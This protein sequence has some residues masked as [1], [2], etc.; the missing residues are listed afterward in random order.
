MKLLKIGSLILS[1]S[2]IV[3]C[4]NSASDS[5]QTTTTAENTQEEMVAA[6]TDSVVEKQ[7][8]DSVDIKFKMKMELE[9]QR[10]ISEKHKVEGAPNIKSF[11]H[12][13]LPSVDDY[14]KDPKALKDLDEQFD[15]KNGYFELTEEGDGMYSLTSCY[16]NRKDGKKL[17][18]FNNY[19]NESVVKAN[20][21]GYIQ[22]SYLL[23]YLYNEETKE[24]E[25]IEAPFN[26]PLEG[27]HLAFMLPQEG[28]DI[29]YNF[30]EEGQEEVIIHTLKWNGMGFDVE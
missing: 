18:A 6:A 26:K 28:K 30:K 13:L 1:A 9:K 11:V 20:T 29:Q 2:A 23:F 16:W 10:M 25:H 4:S 14:Y 8:T 15:M 12:A 17:V 5:T 22:Y 27:E 21:L 19:V 24:L 7:E 3:S